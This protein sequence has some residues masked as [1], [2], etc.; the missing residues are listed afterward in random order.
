MM[1]RKKRS[2]MF[3]HE[4]GVMCM[5]KRGCL[6]LSTGRALRGSTAARRARAAARHETERDAR[7]GQGV[8]R[9]LQRLFI[10][11]EDADMVRAHLAAGVGD[12]LVTVVQG[13]AKARGGQDFGH[14]ALHFDQ[15]F[16]GHFYLFKT[17][18]PQSAPERSMRP[19]RPS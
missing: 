12:Q 19:P 6:A 17:D 2:S 15:F 13:Y 10:A 8:G 5:C 1:W 18:V 16:F 11:R 9:H 14:R 3:S 7:F 4:A